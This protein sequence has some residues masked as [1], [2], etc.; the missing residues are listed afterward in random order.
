MSLGLG[1]YSVG[2]DPAHHLVSADA[3]NSANDLDTASDLD[4]N[5]PMCGL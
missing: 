1:T 5:L 2:T 3:K 4:R